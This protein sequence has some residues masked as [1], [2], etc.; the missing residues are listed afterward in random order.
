MNQNAVA[1]ANLAAQ[2]EI[3]PA[4]ARGFNVIKLGLYG[5]SDGG[6]FCPSMNLAKLTYFEWPTQELVDEL[7]VTNPDL[8]LQS[9]QV[10]RSEDEL[11]MEGIRVTLSTGHTNP[12]TL[13]I[14]YDSPLS[15]TMELTGQP[16]RSIAIQKP[17]IFF[18]N[19]F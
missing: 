6:Q 5:E 7:T 15:T 3:A 10:F 19:L 18:K 12:G 11:D 1:S 2:A 9:L 14:S 13:G 17:K 16:T 4:Q 8:S